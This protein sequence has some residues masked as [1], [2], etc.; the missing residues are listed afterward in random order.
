[1]DD[2]NTCLYQKI[3]DN[4]FFGQLIM[5]ARGMRQIPGLSEAE[6]P[7]VGRPFDSSLHLAPAVQRVFIR[8]S[9]GMLRVENDNPPAPPKRLNV[10]HADFLREILKLAPHAGH[11]IYRRQLPCSVSNRKQT[12]EY[13]YS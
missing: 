3:N 2:A 10:C 12:F 11:R 1:M 6:N 9:G 5:G 7:L 13:E 4:I 8:F